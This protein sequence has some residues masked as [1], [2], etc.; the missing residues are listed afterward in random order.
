M[1]TK[2][3]FLDLNVLSENKDDNLTTKIFNKK[4]VNVNKEYVNYLNKLI[5]DFNLF[6]TFILPQNLSLDLAEIYMEAQKL[7]LKSSSFNGVVVCTQPNQLLDDISLHLKELRHVV[8][9]YFI[10]TTPFYLKPSLNQNIFVTTSGF[11]L[12]AYTQAHNQ[13]D[14]L[15][16]QIDLIKQGKINESEALYSEE[17]NKLIE[18]DKKIKKEL[19]T[20]EEQKEE[21]NKYLQICKQDYKILFKG[22]NQKDI[23]DELLSKLRETYSD[24]SL[25]EILELLKVNNFY[26]QSRYQLLFVT[27]PMI[28]M[29]IIETLAFAPTHHWWYLGLSLI[30]SFLF[31]DVLSYRN[32]ISKKQ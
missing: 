9:E 28:G 31:L 18:A 8:D 15:L 16:K 12:S 10:I 4:Q 23:Y 24:V 19:S 11:N 22:K 17:F 3:L 1:S 14:G 5:E 27:Y 6:I 13:F 21:I 29:S 2:T 30:S 26:S 32:Y 20:K 7:G 25:N